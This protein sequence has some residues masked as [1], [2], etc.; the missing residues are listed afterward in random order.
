MAELIYNIKN[1]FSTNLEGC[2]LDY[3]AEFYHIASYQRGY[4][5]GFDDNGAVSI[6]LNDLRDAYT[7]SIDSKKPIDYYLQ[8]ITLKKSD[9]TN[10]LEVIDG[11]QR[12]TTLSIM[13][14][15][16]SFLTN[17]E[18][19]AKG[20]LDYAVR[21]NF[22]ENYIYQNERIE[23]LL[24][25]EWDRETGLTIGNECFNNQDSFYLFGALKKCHSFFIE[26][27]NENQKGFYDFLLH[28]VQIIVNVVEH[29]NSEKVFS[30]LNSNKVPLTEAELIK[31]LFITKQARIPNDLQK[32]S[33]R[34]IQEQRL[35]LGR[36]WDE[37]ENWVNDKTVRSFYFGSFNDPMF[38]FLSLVAKNIE[39]ISFKEQTSHHE[40]FNFFNHQDIELIQKEL[41]NTFWILK[42]WIKDPIIHNR[43]GYLFFYKGSKF[44]ILD[45]VKHFKYK[46]KDDF[47]NKLLKKVIKNIPN[48]LD[49]NYED[50]PK[51]IHQILLAL[52]VFSTKI[53]YDFY[54][55]IIEN[56]TLEHIFPQTPEGK[57]NVLT[58]VDKNNIIEMVNQEDKEMVKRELKR[59]TRTPEQKTIY[60]DALKRSGYIH[61]LGNMCLLSNVDNILNGCGFYDEKRT[62]LLKRIKNGGFIPSHT[63]EVFTKSI[64]EENPGD[65]TR[66]NKS[67]IDNHRQIIQDKITSLTSLLKE[68]AQ[69]EG[70]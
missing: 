57:K 41:Y 7:K 32:K 20:R 3:E 42:D 39:D 1:V 6:L 15:I 12:L 10:Y 43:L 56:W 9:E 30:N 18:N 66:W 62:K 65:F 28:Q 22:F 25:S 33:F 14:S 67:N 21:S 63:I 55:Y 53:K 58:D 4:K 5:W 47:Y 44:S 17:A 23:L 45:F 2:L 70:R 68:E 35:I 59:K 51:E 26:L 40:L 29:V 36:R 8:Y 24:A 48:G 11:Q 31:A 49:V 60:T 38:G 34:E 37:I 50:N 27:D 64:F 54:N 61:H 16:L 13:L 19:I 52:N 69:Y 46:S